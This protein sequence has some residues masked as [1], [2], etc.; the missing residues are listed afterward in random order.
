[1]LMELNF[2]NR[3]EDSGNASSGVSGDL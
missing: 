1:L 3:I 2:N